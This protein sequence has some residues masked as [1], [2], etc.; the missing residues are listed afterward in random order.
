MHFKILEE[1]LQRDLRKLKPISRKDSFY[2]RSNVVKLRW[3]KLIMVAVAVMA[4]LPLVVSAQAP[5][6]DDMTLVIAQQTDATSLD[7]P[8]GSARPGSNMV[9]HMFGFLFQI[10]DEAN[11][12]PYLATDW[13]LS[14]DRTE[15][16]FT[17]NEGLTC[18]DGEALTA[19]DVVYTFE[20]AV[21]PD[22]AFT[23]NTPGFVLTS[24]GY[25]GARVDS[26]L[27]ATI[28]LDGFTSVAI[29]LLSE[30]HIHCKDSYEAMTLEEAALNPVGSGPY[31]L[32]E[33]VKDDY[34]V[35]E[36]WD[37]FTLRDPY[38]ETIVWRVIPEASTRTAELIAGNVDII[39]NVPGDQHDVINSSDTSSV[40]P[41]EGLRRIFV[42]FNQTDLF[43]SECAEAIKKPEVRRA[44]QYA[45]DV[46]TMTEALFGVALERPTGMVNEP[47]ANP[48]L[49][50][51]E[52]NPDRTRELLTEA[53]YPADENGVHLECN[54]M[55]GRVRYLN[56]SEVISSVCQY[57]SDAGIQTQCDFMDWGSE[58]IPLVLN[59]EAGEL[60]FIGSGGGN[61]NPLYEMADITTFESG[62]NYGGWNNE[63]WFNGWE[64]IAENTD[65][66]VERE[67][68][69]EM[70]EIFY[71]DPPWLLLYMQPDFYGVSNRLDWQPRRDQWLWTFDSPLAT[72]SE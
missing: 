70:L 23:G 66:V 15:V 62:P 22:N 7:P 8:N 48:N 17:L 64:R 24:A 10:D 36:K 44:F 14:D 71:N 9:D 35:M 3:T 11:I 20:R 16:T 68:V 27:E 13:S 5:G 4:L 19:E 65:P 18:H 43:D 46:P 69:N 28:I 60:Y 55:T 40:I 54:L 37:E 29:G 21:D 56:H 6:P 52:Y 2:R 31:R 30:V 45:I 67:I 47:N 63:D 61:W 12:V 53:G 33:W 1:V 49:E 34:L 42:G 57:L 58:F 32:V 72:L 51:Y 25:V 39:T 50:P 38:F 26:E 59:R 41:V